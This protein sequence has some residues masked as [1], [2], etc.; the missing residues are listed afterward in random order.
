M[1]QHFLTALI[2][3]ASLAL[4]STSGQ[5]AISTDDGFGGSTYFTAQT[6]DALGDT[7]V[8]NAVAS[9]GMDN[10]N[11]ESVS[12]IEPAAGGADD[13]G[14][15][16]LPEDPSAPVAHTGDKLNPPATP[17]VPGQTVNTTAK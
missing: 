4:F 17:I 8:T 11:A 16:T 9:G 5:A 6:P 7:P 15:F 1:R 14:V 3:T 13:F 10:D 2:A 12:K